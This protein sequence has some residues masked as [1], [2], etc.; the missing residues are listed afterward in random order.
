MEFVVP[1]GFWLHGGGSWGAPSGAPRFARENM[2]KASWFIALVVG[3]AGGVVADRMITG[4]G[5]R[6]LPP[7]PRAA[8]P[9]A[10]RPPPPPPAQAARVPLRPDDPVKG[11]AVAKV[12]IVEFSDFQCPFC[13]R[14]N[15]TLQQLE[16]AFPGSVRIAWKHQPLSFHPNAL[17]AALAG[18]AAREQGKFW[19]FHDLA[20]QNQQALSPAGYEAWAGQIG[21]DLPRFK[22][23]VEARSGKAR[24]DEDQ[25]LASQVGATATPTLFINCRRVVGALPL[26]SFRP[27]VEE[28]LK[29]AE[30]LLSRGVAL[31]ASFYP[32]A[33]DE[34]VKAMPT[35]AAAEP[36]PPPQPT[37]PV[38]VPLRPDDPARG[39]SRAPVTIVEFSDFQCPFCSRAGPTLRQIEQAYGKDV[40]IVWKHQPLPFHPEAMPAALAAEAAREQGKFWEMHDKLFQNQQALSAP[41]FEA[42]A[43]EIGLDV[44]RWK[45]AL[46]DPR[47]RE[48]IQADQ[49]L[50]GRVGA[51]GT[52]TFFVNGERVIGAQP[53]ESFKAVIDRKLARK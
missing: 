27:I 39:S 35:A 51:S 2:K 5:V 53:F 45:A 22:K 33:C 11:P 21:L 15:P 48:R 7:Q 31:D 23:A 26:E 41:A 10:P 44:P 34:N 46:A 20:F 16:D 50:A 12:T 28:E 17:P 49:Q 52:P 13:G 6:P 40:R 3:F 1:P 18:E 30:A 37:A 29:K 36:A 47:L 19:P 38:D 14:V 42:F 32:R 24:I 25:A 9:A 8:Q 43:R 4:A